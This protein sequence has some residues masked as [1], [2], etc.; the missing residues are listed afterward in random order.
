MIYFLIKL[1]TVLI[2]NKPLTKTSRVVTRGKVCRFPLGSF[3]VPLRLSGTKIRML[4]SI[5]LQML[6]T[7][8]C[9]IVW[10]LFHVPVMVLLTTKLNVPRP[11]LTILVQSS[12]CLL[13]AY[14]IGWLAIK[15]K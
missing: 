9:G 1:D 7:N 4:Y 8:V 5:F 14:P 13:M 6:E 11:Y 2:I 15:S 10:G 3:Y 12:S